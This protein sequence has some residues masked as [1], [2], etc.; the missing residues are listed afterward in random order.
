MP[1]TKNDKTNIGSRPR[2]RSNPKTRLEH[3]FQSK[4][5]PR[6]K[7]EKK[8]P[9]T[10]KGTPK[11]GPKTGNSSPKFGCGNHVAKSEFMWRMP[12]SIPSSGDPEAFNRTQS[13]FFRTPEHQWRSY[14]EDISG[15]AYHIASC[16]TGYI[17]EVCGGEGEDWLPLVVKHIL[18]EDRETFFEPETVEE[19]PNVHNEVVASELKLRFPGVCRATGMEL[20]M[21]EYT[22]LLEQERE[23]LRG[24]IKANAYP[25]LLGL[26]SIRYGGWWQ[27]P[28]WES[29]TK[30]E[31][32]F[33]VYGRLVEQVWKVGP[34]TGGSDE[35]GEEID[36]ARVDLEELLNP[37]KNRNA[38]LVELALMDACRIALAKAA[39]VTHGGTDLQEVVLDE[40]ERLLGDPWKSILPF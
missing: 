28:H 2:T 25:I 23:M 10:E 3:G 21:H 24:E 38:T 11:C 19:S 1:N 27:N 8:G 16:H 22:T 34:Q 6:K 20:L 7:A 4:N 29:V 30:W 31:H 40:M 5:Q 14:Q 32:T 33:P 35:Y 37:A 18:P 17:T 15:L 9:G 39:R 26:Y 13:T 12:G 36:L